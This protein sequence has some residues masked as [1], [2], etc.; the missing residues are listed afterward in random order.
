GVVVDH[1]VWRLELV[2]R[3][4]EARDQHDR[5]PRPPGEPGETARETDEEL[6]VLEPTR[7]LRERPVAGLVVRAMRNVIPDQAVSVRRLLIDADDPIAGLLQERDDLAPAMRVVPVFALRRALHRDADVRL[8]HRTA[9]VAGIEP[10][11]DLGRIDAQDIAG[12][13]V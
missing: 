2:G 12:G 11:R 8:R 3:M 6:G 5:N 1:T 13:A 7:A 9:L 4:R 10:R